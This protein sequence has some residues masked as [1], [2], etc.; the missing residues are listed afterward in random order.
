MKSIKYINNIERI[1]Q[2]S[3]DEIA[4][5]K[6]VTKKY[7]FRANE[8]YLS[9]ID[10]DNPDDPIRRIVI[11]SV[12]ELDDWGDLDISN[13]RINYKAPG[14]QHKYNDTALLVL[15]KTCGSFCRF[16]FRKRLFMP[17]NLE[18]VNDIEPGLEYIRAH[19]EITNVLLTGGEPLLLSTSRLRNILKK[20]AAI[21]HIR[22]IRLGSKIPVFNPY[23]ILDDPKLLDLIREYNSIG[24]HIYVICHINHPKELTVQARQA[25]SLLLETGATLC[26]Q[27]PVLRGINDDA[28]V[29]RELMEELSFIG[30]AP[31]YFFINRPT[32]GNRPFCIPV[33]VAYK[34]FSDATR[35]LSGVARRAKM[36][37]SHS[38][39]KIQV[40]GLTDK[41]IFF[42]YNRARNPKHEYKIFVYKRKDDA[43]WFDD[44]KEQLENI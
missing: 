18:I 26:N 42:R 20:L 24:K 14:L 1:P 35:G 4:A 23:R 28:T 11:P 2:L 36:V 41:H 38:T 37:M 6:K 43:M 29:L 39:G 22:I 9:L 32:K 10:W 27:T 30:I 40:A 12:D 33:T 7:A 34:L 15:N 31:Y 21:P 8:Y 13:E 44:F 3:S 19:K 16:C 17:D 5:L 25:I